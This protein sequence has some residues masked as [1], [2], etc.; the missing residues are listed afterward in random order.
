MQKLQIKAYEKQYHQQ[1]KKISL[2]WLQKND[3][4]EE[5]D[6]DLL[7]NPQHYLD[8]G[9]LIFLAHFNNEIVGTVSLNP[10]GDSVYEIL[11]LGVV[12][13]Y[14]ELG[15]GRKLMQ[16]CIDICQEKGVKSITLETNSK[17]ENAIRLYE[18]V[19]FVH[20]EMKDSYYE[21]SNVKM[22]LKLS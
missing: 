12:D 21:T 6:A 14:K 4:Y 2:D 18:K 16:L 9:A 17:L 3:L 7:D 1:F 15:I 19:G 10:L 5:T 20:I 13:G 8:K 11:K 22:E